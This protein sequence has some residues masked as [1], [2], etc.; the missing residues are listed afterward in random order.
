M[1]LKVASGFEI[2]FPLII[3]TQGNVEPELRGANVQPWSSAA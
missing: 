1:L 3:E 2:A